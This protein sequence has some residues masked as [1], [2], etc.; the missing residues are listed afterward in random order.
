MITILIIQFQLY[1]LSSGRLRDREE[2]IKRKFQIYIS[3]DL[4]CK[5]LVFRKAGR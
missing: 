4:I 1:Y 2:K 5:R 3:R